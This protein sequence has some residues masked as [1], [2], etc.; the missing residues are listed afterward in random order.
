MTE[1]TFT[2]LKSDIIQDKLIDQGIPPPSLTEDEVVYQVVEL[3]KQW[4][5]YV[6]E[7]TPEFIRDLYKKNLLRFEVNN[8]GK[9]V[10]AFYIQPLDQ[11]LTM[12]HSDQIFRIG[13]LS[14]FGNDRSA[15]IKILARFKAEVVEKNMNIIAKT[16]N[17]TLAKY[18]KSMGLEELTAEECK[19]K[20][21]RFVDNYLKM[22]PKSEEYYSEKKFYVG[23]PSS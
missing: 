21:P 5:E 3:Q 16:D 7:Q 2:G 13:G 19:I 9:I 15:V 22:S 8:E 14:T 10:V 11:S 4:K 18:L 20:Y 17:P 23:K 1:K 12:D 6:T